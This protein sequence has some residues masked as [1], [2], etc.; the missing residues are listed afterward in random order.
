M[1]TTKEREV[2]SRRIVLMTTPSMATELERRAIMR[3]TSV[4]HLI[5]E[6]IRHTYSKE[7]RR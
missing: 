4:A 5:R 1:E 6:A 7:E 3:D 2:H